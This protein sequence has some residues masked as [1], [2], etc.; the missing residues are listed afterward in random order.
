MVEESF[1][2]YFSVSSLTT[3]VCNVAS[4]ATTELVRTVITLYVIL[5]QPTVPVLVKATIVGALGYFICP[6][7]LIPD[8]LPGG[9]VD[10]LAILS[11][12]L[13]QVYVYSNQDVRD[14]VEELLPEWS[15]EP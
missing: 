5:E 9:L 10:D 3:K 15:N 12:T 14:R 11:T 13:T 4:I 2:E 1:S 8:F 7:D 6:I